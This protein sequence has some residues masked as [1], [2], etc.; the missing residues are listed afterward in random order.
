MKKFII[1]LVAIVVLGTSGVF[2]VKHFVGKKSTPQPTEPSASQSLTSSSG[3]AQSPTEKNETP[4]T[5]SAPVNEEHSF[6]AEVISVSDNVFE[7]ESRTDD[8]GISKNDKVKVTVD[9]KN[10]FDSEGKAVRD[11][12]FENFS[13]AN[14]TYLGDVLKTSPLFVNAEKVVLS[15]RENCNVYFYI[16]GK[17][18][19]TLTVTKGAGID[20]SDMPHAGAYCDDGY[21]FDYWMDESGK[22]VYSLSSVDDSIVL[23]AKISHD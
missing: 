16:D 23:N 20:S 2:A 10:V 22:A 14:V 12:D 18:I 4:T 5:T 15:Q 9:R 19:K 3:D 21:H 8:N 11:D 17:I 1:A 6:D 13:S 7:L